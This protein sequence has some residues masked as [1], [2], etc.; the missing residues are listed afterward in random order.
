MSA[1]DFHAAQQ[2]EMEVLG[3]EAGEEFVR[4]FPLPKA[5]AFRD[6]IGR[7]IVEADPEYASKQEIERVALQ[8]K[9]W[10]KDRASMLKPR[11]GYGLANANRTK[12]RLLVTLA[13][14]I[15]ALEHAE[16]AR[17]RQG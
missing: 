12:L 6:L 10:E 2:F 9:G 7:E 16:V 8:V 5:R 15:A 13:K 4:C 14:Y 11:D 1:P 3:S 17:R